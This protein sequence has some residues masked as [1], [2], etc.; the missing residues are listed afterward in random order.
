MCSRTCQKM[1][2]NGRTCVLEHGAWQNLA[3]QVFWIIRNMAEHVFHNMAEHMA[4]HSRTRD[5]I[6]M[7]H[8]QTC[9]P[10]YGRIWRIMCSR[11]WPN[12]AEHVFWNMAEHG[13]LGNF[14]NHDYFDNI[15][16]C[17]NLDH[18]DCLDN[19]LV[20]LRFTWVHI[21][22]FGYLGSI[23]QISVHL[24]G[25]QGNGFYGQTDRQ[26]DRRKDR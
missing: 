18:L 23:Q 1:V 5:N 21:F 10:G 3:E 20:T 6:Y 12:I 16:H 19:Y 4:E 17:G 22:Y 26:T 13:P 14:D 2:H 25:S 7:E 15:D 24:D 9:V 11:T 8:C